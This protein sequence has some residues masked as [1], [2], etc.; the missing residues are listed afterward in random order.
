MSDRE[1]SQLLDRAV[2]HAP[3]MHLSGED[4]LAAGKGRVRRRRAVGVGGTLGA[5]A[6][7]AAV[8][9]GLSGGEWS[10]TGLPEVQPATTVFEQGEVV[11]ATLFDGFRTIDT[12]Q[13][14]HSFVGRLTQGPTGP[15]V[16]EVTDN[17]EV[18]ER[19]TA[20]SPLPGLEVFPG[21]TMTVALWREPDG[22]VSSVPLVG[23]V[24]PGGPSGREQVEI[25]GEQFGS[26][27]YAA[28]V[29]GVQ[30]PEEFLDVY[31]V[32]RDG[33]SA[34]SGA[35]LE[36]VSLSG[37]SRAD[38]FADES[39]GIVGYA[40]RDQAPVLTQIGDRPA[41]VHSSIAT[42][43]DGAEA[44]VIL[45]QGAT[46]F[47]LA[48][49][50]TDADFVGTRVLERPF[51]LVWGE[52]GSTDVGPRVTFDLGG[53]SYDLDGY[54]QDLQDL[55]LADGSSVTI[56]P[57]DPG[58]PVQIGRT[59]S[60]APMTRAEAGSGPGVTTTTA[61]GSLV[62]LADG[63]DTG[64]TVLADARVETSGGEGTRWITPTDV[65]QVVLP[66][67]R[68]VTALAVPEVDGTTVTGVGM[69]DG[70]DVERWEPPVAAAGVEWR[71]VDGVSVP[72]DDGQPLPR[73][74]DGDSE[75][76]RHY[77]GVD[78]ET[79]YLVLPG[80]G[81]G[82]A[83]VPLAFGV[84]PGLQ[85]LPELVQQVDRSDIDGVVSTV[86][87]LTGG[88]SADGSSAVMAVVAQSVGPE[89]DANTW[90]IVGDA[91]SGHAVLDPGLGVSLGQDHGVWILYPQGS[92]DP[93]QLQAGIINGTVLESDSR[94]V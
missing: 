69:A 2:Q 8:W 83:F 46:D 78:E 3:P 25:D 6:I 48:D 33:A 87:T 90:Q 35:L 86:L 21:E 39:R 4:V 36:W 16:L 55:D 82:P 61:G 5:A 38:V 9:A 47:G 71:Q 70:D 37:R 53:R 74:D 31:L 27:V 54:A 88:R 10:L 73:I 66:D 15:L 7:V 26:A 94:E 24:D 14:A 45:P 32:G 1:L 50:A 85:A 89:G 64:A 28:G 13:V 79:S 51:L 75:A 12:E 60:D 63:W 59:G 93:S 58:G 77:A 57:G 42:T 52:D 72:Y 43:D 30:V 68:L 62:V 19:I 40:V 22:V 23:P 18:A 67:G 81:A 49:G 65:A 41:Q 17:G 29:D 34:L 76:F 84:E 44:V 80:Q 92:V 11:D 56:M 91:G 20:E